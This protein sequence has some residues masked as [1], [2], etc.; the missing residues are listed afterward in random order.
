MGKTVKLSSSDG[1][2]FE[3]DIE[4]AKMSQTINNMLGDLGDVDEDEV[5]PLSNVS[6]PILEK[7]LEYAKKHKDDPPVNNDDEKT[8]KTFEKINDWDRE[9]INVD[10]GTLFE[11]I[12]AANY[13]YMKGLIDLGCQTV[14]GMIKGKSPEEIRKLYNIANDFTPEE[15]EAIRKENEWAED[16]NNCR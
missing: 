13:L 4:V 10:H 2:E 1:R 6:G 16:S 5:I 15:E 14:A 8:P 9:F 12:L 11:I 7:V 3:V